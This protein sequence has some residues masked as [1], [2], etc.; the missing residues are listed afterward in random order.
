MCQ[1]AH[2]HPAGSFARLAT[3]CDGARFAVGSH[4]YA[5][6]RLASCYGHTP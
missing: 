2:R 5:Y 1:A 4:Y 3:A 6:D